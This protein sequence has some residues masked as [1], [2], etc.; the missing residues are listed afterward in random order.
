MEAYIWL[1]LACMFAVGILFGFFM[2]RGKEVHPTAKVR[3]LEERLEQA[4]QDMDDYRGE[5]SEHFGKTAE[6]FN[7]L[8]ND[9]RSVYEHLAQSSEKLCGD[10]VEK[11][12]ALSSDSG[13]KP[14]IESEQPV[15]VEES[16]VAKEE[17]AEAPE[18]EV[19]AESLTTEDVSDVKD[20]QEVESKAATEEPSAAVV[21]EAKLDDKASEARTIH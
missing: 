10:Q 15:Q 13:E 20:S 7:Q 5:V 12:K 2:G 3:E 8:T 9:Y 16:V 4:H 17:T 14:L 1:I 21:E 6:L 11:L 18:E 19:K